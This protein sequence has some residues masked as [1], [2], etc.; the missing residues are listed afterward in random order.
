MATVS[1]V[2]MYMCNT[3]VNMFLM[4]VDENRKYKISLCTTVCVT[5]GGKQTGCGERSVYTHVWIY[6]LTGLMPFLC[7]PRYT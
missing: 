4:Q 1:T 3:C 2:N 5:D 6:L 7:A